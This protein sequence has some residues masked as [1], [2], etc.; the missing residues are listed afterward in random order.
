[1]LGEGSR[2]SHKFFTRHRVRLFYAPHP[3]LSNGEVAS[4]KRPG[5]RGGRIGLSDVLP[6]TSRRGPASGVSVNR[7]PVRLSGRI[8]RGLPR[9]TRALPPNEVPPKHRRRPTRCHPNIEGAGAFGALRFALLLNLHSETAF[10]LIPG[11]PMKMGAPRGASRRGKAEHEGARALME[12]TFRDRFPSYPGYHGT[13]STLRTRRW[14]SCRSHL[15]D[16]PSPVPAA[17]KPCAQRDDRGSP[18]PGAGPLPGHLSPGGVRLKPHARPPDGRRRR[19]TRSFH[20][21]R[22]LQD[23]PRSR[24]LGRLAGQGLGQALSVDSNQQR[25]ESSSR[26]AP[27][28]LEPRSQRGLG[29]QGSGVARRQLRPSDSRGPTAQGSPGSI[30][31]RNTRLATAARR[32]IASSTPRWRCSS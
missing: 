1:M 23:R 9:A 29:R 19:A 11:A 3:S 22:Q 24:R 21:L 30:V 25:R 32:S 7:M 17:P 5:W 15:P 12:S 20:G 8:S 6:R 14:W 18:R 16:D 27:I 2:H 4:D 10:R 31:P 13:L 26:P 28:R